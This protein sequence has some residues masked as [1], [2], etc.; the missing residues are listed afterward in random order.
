MSWDES[1][2]CLNES[3]LMNRGTTCIVEP[4]GEAALNK[5]TALFRPGNKWF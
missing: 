1:Q 4:W 3:Q 5:K 2:I